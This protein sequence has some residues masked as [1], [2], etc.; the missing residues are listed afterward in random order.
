MTTLNKRIVRV[1]IEKSDG[2]FIFFEDL[3]IRCQGEKWAGPESSMA[4]I[5]I[6]NLT[7]EQ[8]NFI[9][10]VASPMQIN[11]TGR[12]TPLMVTLDVGRENV[13]EP[14][15]LFQGYCYASYVT[16]PP[17]IGIVL[18]STVQ[19]LAA[20]TMMD[21]NW[22]ALANIS[23]IAASVASTYGLTLNF[24]ATD[25]KVANFHYT[26]GLQDAL[27]KL[28][29]SGLVTVFVDNTVL[30]VAD[31][32]KKAGE[33]SPFELN[34]SSGMVGIPE[35]C[36]TGVNARCLI[37]P[38][39]QLGGEITVMSDI[40]PAVNGNYL[41]SHIKYEIANRDDPFW[42]EMLLTNANYLLGNQ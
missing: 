27:N 36:E 1:G 2:D 28:A 3:D 10:T 19:S 17:D 13:F 26:G 6:S 38:E 31:K 40:N 37:R 33:A 8:K 18:E 30:Y 16:M 5:Q 42:Y 15:R 14:F 9:L 32:G 25:K 22:G 39:I 7:R 29:M 20:S 11:V 24:T 35:V 4:R 34:I 12:R 21:M 41:A 23:T